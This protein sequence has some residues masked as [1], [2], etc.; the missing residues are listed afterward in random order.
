MTLIA[1]AVARRES[2]AIDASLRDAIRGN[3][4]RT[5]GER[6]FEFESPGAYLVKCDI[7]AF[8]SE[9]ARVSGAGSV[10]LLAGEPLLGDTDPPSGRMRQEDLARIH[11]RL[12][13][14]E[15]GI[16]R[17]AN[18]SYC[19]V[20]YDPARR[21]LVLAGDKLGLR[22]LYYW[23]DERTV[24]F[25]GALRILESMEQVPKVMDVGAVAE[26]LA[27]G[28]PQGPRTPYATIRT[29]LSGQAI[30]FL[31]DREEEHR[32]W[33][34]DEIP[35]GPVEE[36]AVLDRLMARFRGAVRR[37]LGTDRCARAFL[38]GGLDSRCVVGALRAEDVA[39]HTYTF[40]LTGSRDQVY[41]DRFAEAAGVRHH[42]IRLD[43]PTIPS[44]SMLLRETLERTAPAERPPVDR[45]GLMWAGDGG[46]VG[47]GCSYMTEELVRAFRAGPRDA[48]IRLFLNRRAASV[49]ARILRPEVARELETAIFDGV[50]EEFQDIHTEDGARALHLFLVLNDQRRHLAEHFER[51]DLH[52]VEFVLPFFDAEFLSVPLS[53][54]VD[55]F[56]RHRLYNRWLDR[57]PSAVHSVPWQAYPGHEPC[58]LAGD[59]PL[60]GQWDSAYDRL[61]AKKERPQFL[62]TASAVLASREF[63]DS[64]LDRRS[65]QVVTGLHRLGLRD[66]RYLITAA[67]VFA[68]YWRQSGGRA[69]LPSAKG[70]RS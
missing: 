48:A 29:L 67:D 2:D 37:R 60:T 57:F 17:E 50:R 27:H 38:S 69:V 16:L 1:G 19:A 56:L 9:A 44:L 42:P 63:P 65:L 28:Y 13:R 55:L 46:S 41:S 45:P 33:R 15:W 25:A 32:Y 40:A 31:P 6:V 59:E 61:Q 7:G 64:L 36:K 26:I 14:D 39:V 8:G 54:P 24:I 52:R 5:P 35:Q 23:S 47:V 12:D 34:W 70:P 20:H 66:Y 18:G 11:D 51:I 3:L 4:S 68:R 49:R 10:S 53:S 58:P 62:R 22:P 30:R 21:A 43:N